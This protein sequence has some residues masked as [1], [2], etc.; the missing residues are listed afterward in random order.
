MMLS[1]NIAHD[2]LSPNE[3]G[4]RSSFQIMQRHLDWRKLRRVQMK[5][6]SAIFDI[7]N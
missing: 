2:K 5:L 6:Y 7:Y 3:D 1:G 4:I